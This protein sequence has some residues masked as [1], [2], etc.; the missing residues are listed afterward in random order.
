MTSMLTMMVK[1]LRLLLRD[2]FGLFW[3]FVFPLVYALFFGAIFSGQ[4]GGG[5]KIGVAVVDQDKSAGSK[6]FTEKLAQHRSLAVAR[7]EDGSMV[8][9][10]A[11]KARDLVRRGKRAA[12]VLLREGFGQRGLDAFAFAGQTSE[13]H[14][15]V[16]VDPSRA[17]E[18]GYLQGILAELSI[19]HTIDGFSDK[20][21]TKSDVRR[22][23][24]RFAD[25]A[26]VPVTQKLVLS[27]FFSALEKFLTGVDLSFVAQNGGG[28]SGGGGAAA[29]FGAV[30]FVDV[31][32]KK[33]GPTSSFQISFPS[34]ILWGLIGCAAG[35]AIMIVRERTQGTMTRLLTS[36]I[37]RTA[38]LVG[39]GAACFVA[40]TAAIVFLL[41][42][43][44]LGLG[45]DLGSLPK[46][47]AA[48]FASATCFVGIMLV[49]SLLGRT[50]QAVAGAT[51]GVM[52]PLAMLGGGMVPLIAMPDWMQALS[53]VSP[54][55]WCVL[56]LEGAIWRN[57]SWGEL[58]VPCGILVAVGLG[59][60]V[61]A[62]LLFR[63]ALA[64]A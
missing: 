36:P 27:V 10:E 5:G 47:V 24:K 21:Q 1:D 6:A 50:E 60:A 41:L 38:I 16:G 46:L 12:Y 55:K 4:S 15:E 34:A 37:S 42:V 54:F 30:D 43:A 61:V 11:D 31:S 29:G 28:D 9:H 8:L 57:F 35:F 56:A 53:N 49:C 32:V 2:R 3:I 63:R 26:S 39:K 7:R 14:V 22:F 25:D 17:A 40:C 52:M 58:L 59:L 64:R 20:E 23:A 48:I 62:S 51:W 45:I 33:D 13:V 18:R 44:R 19:R